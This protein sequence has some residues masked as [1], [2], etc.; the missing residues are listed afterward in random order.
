MSL[1]ISKTLILF[2][3]TQLSYHAFGQW[4]QIPVS[5][6]SASIILNCNQNK[7]LIANNKF[8]YHNNA[9][10]EFLNFREIP[11]KTN[12]II[13]NAI[14]TSDKI[15][16][17]VNY[18]PNAA[19]YEFNTVSKSLRKL[20]FL[21]EDS[22]Q[23]NNIR[24]VNNRIYVSVF[25]FKTGN[26]IPSIL[27]TENFGTAWQSD[28]NGIFFPSMAGFE[29]IIF[30]NNNY[31]LINSSGVY[32]RNVIDTIWTQYNDGI[33]SASTINPRNILIDKNTIYLSARRGV[34]R[35]NNDSNK[36]EAI[37]DGFLDN[38]SVMNGRITL[39]KNTLLTF[40]L[41][42]AFKRRTYTFNSAIN[43]WERWPILDRLQ[44][45]NIETINDTL[46][47][48]SDQGLFNLNNVYDS[49]NLF[50]NGVNNS[51]IGAINF[52]DGQLYGIFSSSGILHYNK[53]INNNPSIFN[54]PLD[55][56]VS[57]IIGNK[58]KIIISYNKGLGI[59]NKQMQ[60][61]YFEPTFNNLSVSAMS[62]CGDYLFVNVGQQNYR[63]HL[64][65]L[66]WDLLELNT[67]IN[68]FYLH[69]GYVYASSISTGLHRNQLGSNIWES[70]SGALGPQQINDIHA[71]GNNIIVA[72]FNGI[73]LYNTITNT[74]KKINTIA[75]SLGCV[76]LI[77]YDDK[78]IVNTNSDM[79]IY[80]A[81]TNNFILHPIF[82][83]MPF[84][85]SVRQFLIHNDTLFAATSHGIWYRLIN[86]LNT[87]IKNAV[88]TK[89]NLSIYPNPTADI[90]NIIAEDKILEVLITSI[91]GKHI[92]HKNLNELNYTINTF[93]FNSGIY[94]IN[95]KLQNSTWIKE[96]IAI[97]K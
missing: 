80:I 56:T 52:I 86:Q 91:D 38:D 79:G 2:L 17:G 88:L 13:R 61:E 11:E 6:G 53:G 83:G 84:K 74:W 14:A 10:W 93:D 49:L 94:I 34:Y 48:A 50:M 65:T 8:Y 22:F 41:N 73:L 24:F 33:N 68:K 51:N 15:I 42:S 47:I 76:R 16:M 32:K 78:I 92:F 3:F 23:I 66:R 30:H 57:R 82:N 27:F 7:Y 70:V 45:N 31:Y 85:I 64:D 90:L 1:K 18:H 21:L 4:K 44:I 37:N 55:F 59:Y 46:F 12:T 25:I 19:F 89:P 40:G 54:N 20:N 67:R 39:F 28:I 77:V 69:N 97:V 75:D 62:I 87:S 71:F 63:C 81:D 43:K 5:T 29:D 36:W 35:L 60:L 72:T 58:Q 9:K 96:K 95:I 26:I